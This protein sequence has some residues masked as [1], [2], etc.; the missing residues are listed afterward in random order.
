MSQH[1]SHTRQ[2]AASLLSLATVVAMLTSV[3]GVMAQSNDPYAKSRLK[4]VE[5]NLAR[6]G[7]KNESLLRAMG[8]VPR[9]LFCAPKWRESAYFDQSLPIGHGQ[10][11]ESPFFVAYM[12]EKLDPRPD[13]RVL[14]IGTGSGYQAAVLSGL[15]KEVYTIEIIEALGKKAAGLLKE[16]GYRNI[17]PR[18][19][20]GY[21]GWPEH[22]PFDKII[23][24]C[25]PEDVPQPLIDQLRDGG[26]LII[27]LGEGFDQELCIVEKKGGELVKNKLLLFPIS[28]APMRGISDANRSVPDPS[29]STIRNGGFEDEV[30][31]CPKR[32]HF[33][34]Q[35][36]YETGEAPEGRSF[37]TFTNRESGRAAMASQGFPLDGTEVASL[38][39]DVQAKGQNLKFGRTP[40][41]RPSLQVQFYGADRKPLEIAI[42]GPWEETFDWTRVSKLIPVPAETQGAILRVGLNGGTGSLSID[43]VKMKAVRR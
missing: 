22:S 23:V 20:D 39:V 41:E 10:T 9:H 33:R 19:G 18:I 17:Y 27:P 3:A 35:L 37:V 1:H 6:E 11:M 15:V 24:T 12:T 40:L 8:S 42:V 4:M 36:T 34:R 7:I 14:E 21:R 43:D 5:T 30:N 32:W 28:F 16:Q 13:D 38:Q 2:I 26:K 25:S 31:G 29:Q